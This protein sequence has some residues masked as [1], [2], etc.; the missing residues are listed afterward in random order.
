MA[1]VVTGAMGSVTFSG[2]D[3]TTN[4]DLFDINAEIEIPV[5]KTTP[6]GWI[7]T[8]RSVGQVKDAQ[9]TCSGYCLD[10]GKPTIPTGT[11]GTMTIKVSGSNTI[12]FKAMFFSLGIA[13]NST[14]DAPQI[15][16]YQFGAAA[17][18]STDTVT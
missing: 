2:G 7:L 10:S 1:I 13:E 4:I 14:Q 8:R 9:G 16:R 15:A 17:A 6:F 18:A 5:Y 3:S 11:I 12:V